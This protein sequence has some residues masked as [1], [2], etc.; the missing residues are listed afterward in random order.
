MEIETLRTSEHYDLTWKY[1][2]GLSLILY[3][4][5]IILEINPAS[6]TGFITYTYHDSSSYTSVIWQLSFSEL[7]FIMIYRSIRTNIQIG[8]KRRREEWKQWHPEP[9]PGFR[10]HDEEEPIGWH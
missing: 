2:L 7:F 4:I 8:D 5:K 6:V 3:R 1:R 9:A 10:D